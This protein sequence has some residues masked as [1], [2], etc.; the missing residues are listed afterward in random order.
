[1]EIFEKLLKPL[2]CAENFCFVDELES[3]DEN[4]IV[5]HYTYKEDSPFHDSHFKGNPLVP[6]VIMIETMGQI[7]MVCHLL[8]ITEDYSFEN[9]PVLSNL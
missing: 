9:L 5:G 6:G 1:M 3:I 7:G 4:N 8:Y 2:P